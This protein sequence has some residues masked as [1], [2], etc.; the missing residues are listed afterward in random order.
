[1]EAIDAFFSRH[2]RVI[3]SFS[4]G[5]DSA[6]CL[7][8]LEDYWDR[9]TV[10]WANG[11]NPYSETVAYMDK[12]AQMVPHFAVVNGRQPEVVEKFGWPVDVLPHEATAVGKMASNDGGPKLQL[13]SNCCSLNLWQPVHQYCLENK[14]TGV[15]RGQK[16]LDRLTAPMSS[17]S[18]FGGIEYLLPLE[19]W[20]DEMV[21]EFLGDARTPESYLRGIE[22]SLD[23]KNC[24][25]YLFENKRRVRD[26]VVTDPTAYAQVKRVHLYLHRKMVDYTNLMEA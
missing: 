15:I 6:A 7:Y 4:A 13:F 26:L 10:L 5:K 20:T 14:V 3:L 22:S 12:I 16:F 2:E 25:A 19:H 1:M 11:G 8:L 17:G 21:F 23:C 24:T 9:M 18:V